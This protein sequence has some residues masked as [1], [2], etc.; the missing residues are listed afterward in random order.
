MD[1]NKLAKN[2]YSTFPLIESTVSLIIG[3]QFIGQIRDFRFL[4]DALTPQEILFMSN[5]AS[6]YSQVLKNNI[7]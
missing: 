5:T 2:N 6:V 3:K 7:L 1:T 4:S